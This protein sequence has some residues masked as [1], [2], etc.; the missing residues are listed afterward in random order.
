M[1]D[2][3][4]MRTWALKGAEQRLIE[5]SEEAA[6]IYRSFPELRDR[7][8]GSGVGRRGPGRKAQANGSAS[9]R[10]KRTMSADARRRISEAQKARW[11]K[12]KANGAESQVEAAPASAKTRKGGRKKR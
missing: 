5:I 12:Q 9:P 4:A 7:T 2:S 1:T 10:R 8:N 11:A 6:A 3:A